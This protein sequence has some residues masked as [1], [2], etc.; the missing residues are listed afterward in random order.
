MSILEILLIA[1][2]LAMDSFTVSIC[3]GLSMKKNELEKSNN[4]RII[5]WD[6]PSI[7]ANNRILFR[8][9]V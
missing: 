7:N 5:L 3:K 2:G 9:N 1:I 4:S 8:F 6:I